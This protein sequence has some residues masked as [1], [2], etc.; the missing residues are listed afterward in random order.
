MIKKLFFKASRP[1]TIDEI[2]SVLELKFPDHECSLYGLIGS[3]GIKV[4]KTAFAGVRVGKLGNRI[5]VKRTCPTYIGALI[6]AMLFNIIS[7][8]KNHKLAVEVVDYLKQIYG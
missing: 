7:S 5:V 4:K 6:D 3:K 2:K 8:S 1:V